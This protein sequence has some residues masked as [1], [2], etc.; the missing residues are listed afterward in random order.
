[1]A[2]SS[3][4]LCTCTSDFDLPRRNLEATCLLRDVSR[5]VP[6]GDSG[7]YWPKEIARDRDVGAVRDSEPEA[8]SAEGGSSPRPKSTEESSALSTTK[9]HRDG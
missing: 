1:M 6:F 7:M 3:V 2:S 9:S 5:T 8:W 4:K